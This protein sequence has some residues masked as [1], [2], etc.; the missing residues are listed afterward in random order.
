M[1]RARAG[2]P[3]RP[4]A[5]A[6][7]LEELTLGINKFQEL[8]TAIHDF[9]QD[10]FPYRDAARSKAELKFRECL[11]QTFGERAQE[12]QTYRNFK[13]RTGDKGETAQSLVVITGL[14]QTLMD[15]KLELQGLKPPPT[16]APASHPTPP[17]AKHLELVS[18]PATTPEATQTPQPAPP[19]VAATT[20]P[21]V[22]TSIPPST[23]TAPR[24]S[25]IKPQPPT[26]TPISTLSPLPS[27][28]PT[29][30][31]QRTSAPPATLAP[32]PPPT[33]KP[34]PATIE[35][36]AQPT[37]TSVPLPPP[38]TGPSPSLPPLLSPID[39]PL[40]AI[41]RPAA[42][43]ITVPASSPYLAP[44]L[45]VPIPES[46]QQERPSTMSPLGGHSSQ[47]R[48]ADTP[49][50]NLSNPTTIGATL[51][52][53][54]L[55]LIRKVCLRFHSVARQL[56]LRKDYRPTIEV[57]DEYDLQDL[58][59]ALMKVEFDEVA[60]D[61]WTPPYTKGASRTTLVVNRDQIAIVAKKTGPG[62]TTKELTDQVL[63]DAA[64]YR[65][66]GRCSTLFCFVYDPEGRIG[67]PKRLETTLT[68]VSEHCRIEV[69]VAPK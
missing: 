4:R 42:P 52:Q 34:S 29:P 16:A 30:P 37:V 2:E 57:D 15:R 49:S 63:A 44:H 31:E 11:R 69:L 50:L 65:T 40:E 39:R 22:E 6:D 60:T 55:S 38:I 41:Q 25:T 3:Q 28:L 26:L 62:L 21:Y 51:D 66:Q 12:F 19:T 68:S 20:T 33:P 54:P 1:A 35:P 64:Y 56:R 47:Q 8:L 58:L 45:T 7:L 59:C 13:I 23:P 32:V 67:S 5:K 43:L 46:S 17:P 10:G 27:A 18:T 61:E 48:A 9:S 53:D 24:Q 14:I 36:L